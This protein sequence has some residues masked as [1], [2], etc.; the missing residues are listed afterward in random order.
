[1]NKLNIKQF[2]ED[3]YRA[4]NAL[5]DISGQKILSFRAPAFSITEANKWAFEI[6]AENGIVNDASIF[7][8]TRDFGGYRG[9]PSDTP[10]KI[11][12]NGITL[13]EFPIPLYKIPIVNKNIPF[14]GGGYFRLLPY[15][16]VKN[17]I[18][19]S[20]HSICYFHIED[21]LK[22]DTHKLM[23]RQEY[24]DY[25]KETGT[26]IKRI[27]RHFKS[28]VGRGNSF[29]NFQKLLKDFHF[30]SINKFSLEN[31]EWQLIE[32]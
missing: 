5:Q 6:L 32:L 7:P 19:R 17:C 31:K 21:F 18:K 29:N 2:R 27:S 16:F 13:N 10:C 20:E 22:N 24:E 3:T 12:Y 11:K 23:T 25:F 26:L 15:S 9:F 14:S 30:T 8:T 1:M 28:N 4:I